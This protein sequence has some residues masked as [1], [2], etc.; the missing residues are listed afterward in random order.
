MTIQDVL[1]N[2]QQQVPQADLVP[3]KNVALLLERLRGAL[4]TSAMLIVLWAGFHWDDPSSWVVGVP[5][6]LIGGALTLFLPASAPLRLS[7]FGG[8]RF[9]IFALVGILRGAIDVSR[10]SL[11][12]QTLRPG[13]LS[14]RTQLPKGRPR[15][16]FAVAIT[17][18]P[19]TLTAKIEDDTLTVHA[20]DLS[21]ATRAELASLEAHIAKLYKLDHKEMLP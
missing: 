6:A 10:R 11:S 2:S 21:D 5:T 19:G 14:W 18:L 3:H 15:R 20:L 7:P 9:A 16:L 12:P 17:L 8:L 1:L 13:C 4:A